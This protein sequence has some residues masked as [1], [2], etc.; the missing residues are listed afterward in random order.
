[1]FSGTVASR[2]YWTGSECVI[3]ETIHSTI[4]IFSTLATDSL[5]LIL[6]L[7][8]LL[9]WKEALHSDGIFRLMYAQVDFFS[10][11]CF[12]QL[13]RTVGF[14]VVSCCRAR[15]SPPCSAF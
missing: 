14:S 9:R 4:S 1:M 15:R 10:P 13:T 12:R 2:G 8:G 6:M 5:L 3:Q 11:I 7:T